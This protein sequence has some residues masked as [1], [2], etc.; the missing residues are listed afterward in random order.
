MVGAGVERSGSSLHLEA[1]HGSPQHVQGARARA[2]WPVPSV[3]D[4]SRKRGHPRTA[5]EGGPATVY[6]WGMTG[7]SAAGG[8]SYLLTFGEAA[9]L[10]GLAL[11]DLRAAVRNGRIET[12]T[13][14]QFGHPVDLIRLEDLVREFP[15]AAERTPTGPSLQSRGIRLDPNAE[16][17][18]PQ[19]RQVTP[20]SAEAD[21]LRAAFKRARVRNE[22]LVQELNASGAQMRGLLERIEDHPP[23]PTVASTDTEAA[24]SPDPATGSTRLSSLAPVSEVEVLQGRVRRMRTLALVTGGLALLLAGLGPFLFGN[25]NVHAGP[26]T[27]DDGTPSEVDGEPASTAATEDTGTDAPASLDPTG[28]PNSL[29]EVSGPSTEPD[30]DGGPGEATDDADVA[31]TNVDPT[32]ASAEVASPT[33][34]LSEVDACSWFSR[35]QSGSDLREILGPCEGPWNPDLQAVSGIHVHEGERYCRHH[36]FFG[37]RLGGALAEQR[38]IARFQAREG[39]LAPLMKMRVDR[40]AQHEVRGRTGGWL[41]SGFEALDGHSWTQGDAENVWVLESWVHLVDAGARRHFRLRMVISDGATG[42]YTQSFDW[43]D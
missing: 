6:S 11:L 16:G 17:F 42:D 7:S 28:A 30:T 8:E 37:R 33:A 22:E 9:D 41:T 40:A 12:R 31:N 2:G 32:L 38:D 26:Q 14:W 34:P 13:G 25:R 18:T 39:H 15:A 3:G 23:A 21:D 27:P 10:A 24:T 1:A 36:L 43:L 19:P 29:V 4:L 35:T 5:L 20:P